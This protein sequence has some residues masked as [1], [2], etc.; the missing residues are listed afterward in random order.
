MFFTNIKLAEKYNYLNEKF[1]AAYE[2]LR[3]NDL[4]T[5]EPGKYEIM[6]DNVFANVHEYNTL[7]VEEKK[8]EAHDKFFDIQCL[9]DG[10]EFFGLCNREGLIVSEARPENDIVLYEKPEVYGHVIL[11]PGDFI[12]V[13]PEDAHMPGCALA[14]PAAAKKVVVKVR[15]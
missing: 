8:F 11:Y 4:K 10:V 15:V 1:L 6:G 9:V 5:L 14:S 7:P 13:A 3:N 12:V 2:W